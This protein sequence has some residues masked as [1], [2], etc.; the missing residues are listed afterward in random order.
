MASFT[1]V[2]GTRTEINNTPIV[3]G[4]LLFETDQDNN[5]K[6]YA[7]TSPIDRIDIG[8]YDWA[9]LVL[10]FRTIGVGLSVNNNV[11]SQVDI[12]W[13][14]VRNKIFN[15]IGNGL[16]VDINDRLNLNT[17]GWEDIKN[18]LF[19]TVGSR[20]LVNEDKEIYL[21]GQ[22]WDETANRP[23]TS[24]G[25]GLEINDYVLEA[26]GAIQ[27]GLD[28]S[29]QIINKPFNTIGST[30]TVADGVLS[31]NASL[32]GVTWA[33]VTEKPFDT[34]GSGLIIDGT[35]L[36]KDTTE[37]KSWSD[38]TDKPFN[39][40][41][42]GLTVTNNTLSALIKTATLETSTWTSSGMTFS[43]D[44]VKV[45]NTTIS[46]VYGTRYIE[47]DFTLSR[48][49]EVTV[50]FTSSAI[51]ESSTIKIYTD[52]Y[53]LNFKNAVLQNGSCT[54]TFPKCD[55]APLDTLN[56]LCR[57]YIE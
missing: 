14:D 8:T 9:N 6:I 39:T 41:G 29:T 10:P 7:D 17:Q 18:K 36:K 20:L 57:I 43:H 40:V 28:W 2:W 4:Q 1:T 11:L 35:V 19:A 32:S 12:T 53:G 16:N 42:A 49:N 44:L 48:S 47:Q 45:N 13:S 52:L 46:E 26:T 22:T 30:L 38:I 50:T 24:L 27:G 15:T 31:A 34:I 25:V 55:I 23:F 21:G 33:N 56:R 37:V 3:D 5:I 51:T 54:I